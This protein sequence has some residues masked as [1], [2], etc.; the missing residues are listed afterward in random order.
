MN[1]PKIG[2][3]AS[4]LMDLEDA[5]KTKTPLYA[6]ILKRYEAL[7]ALPESWGDITPK[8]WTPEQRA[9]A[10]LDGRCGQCGLSSCDHTAG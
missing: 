2:E 3:L 7:K 10:I 6:D 5:G 1:N 9:L 4:K 8:F